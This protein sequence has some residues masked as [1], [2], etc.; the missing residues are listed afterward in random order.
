MPMRNLHAAAIICTL[1]LSL[2]C[3]HRTLQGGGG[4]G[5]D[6][7]FECKD[8]DSTYQ[9]VKKHK[10][11]GVCEVKWDLFASNVNGDPAHGH[12]DPEIG[13]AVYS[14]PGNADDKVIFDHPGKKFGFCVRPNPGGSDNPA[15]S[16][17]PNSE[18][19]PA[20]T[21]TEQGCD[22]SPFVGSG[23][24]PHA[25]HHL[26]KLKPQ[27]TAECHY[28]LTFFFDDGSIID[29]HIVVGTK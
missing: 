13:L 23:P 28:K 25:K 1:I 6:D 20:P 15:A 18:C 7:R 24:V 9:A 22:L 29:P 14:Q 10:V 21:Q 17:E 19:T 5:G 12:P 16:P 2:G 8:L 4:K 11:N 27:R 3:H 26:P